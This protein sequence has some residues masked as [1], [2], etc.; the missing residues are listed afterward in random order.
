MKNIEHRFVHKFCFHIKY[1]IEKKINKNPETRVRSTLNM[2]YMYSMFYIFIVKN[3]GGLCICYYCIIL[4]LKIYV[5]KFCFYKTQ[6]KDFVKKKKHLF[7]LRS[8]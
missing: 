8:E 5:L 7:S 6:V 2:Y 4:H 3:C 1:K